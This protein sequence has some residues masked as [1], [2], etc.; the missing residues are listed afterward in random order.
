MLLM[1]GNVETSRSAVINPV[2]VEIVT[3]TRQQSPLQKRPRRNPLLRP[4]L[5]QRCFFLL[6]RFFSLSSSQLSSHVQ[7]PRP[8]APKREADEDPAAGDD[9]ATKKAHFAAP[10]TAPAPAPSSSTTPASEK[11]EQLR[12]ELRASMH[13]KD[14]FSLSSIFLHSISFRH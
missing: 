11:E 4:L 2:V 8:K 10:T 6:G 13:R 1:S 9:R 12:D 7:P 3:L 5:L 14:R